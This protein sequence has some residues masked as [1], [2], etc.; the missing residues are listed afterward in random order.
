M[1]ELI[2]KSVLFFLSG[3]V[4]QCAVIAQPATYGV[5]PAPFSS[6]SYHELAPVFY[7]N[8]I[9]F[10]TNRD[11]GLSEYS[12]S[13]N[14]GFLKIFYT[15]TLSGVK[16]SDARLFS[17]N[18]KTKLN[19]GPVTFN[20][21]FDTIYFSRN[22]IVEGKLGNI[23]ASKNKLGLFFSVRSGKK[24]SAPRGLRLNN[25]YYNITTPCLSPDGK[26]MYF[27][28]DK[29]GGYGGS[30]L[31]YSLWRNDYWE[32][33]VNLG[34]AIN[35]EGNESYPFI[36]GDGELLF[37]SD[38][39]GGNGGKDI[40]YSRYS[41]TTW[42][43]P[44]ALD[45][46]VNSAAD[47][48]GIISDK[49]LGKGYF[50]SNRSGKTLD[51]YQF[52]TN[53][54]QIFYFENQRPDQYCFRFR[55][56]SSVVADPV[57]F[58]YEWDFGDGSVA[59]GA[60]TEHCFEGPGTYLINE[61][62]IER[63]TGRL[64]LNKLSYWLELKRVE[65]PFIHSDDAAIAGD[66]MTFD[67]TYSLFTDNDIIAHTWDFGDGTRESG[68]I[69]SH[70]YK[71]PGS[72]T[73]KLGLLLQGH[74]SMA[75]V[76]R[77]AVSKEVKI[78]DDQSQLEAF[79]KNVNSYKAEYHDL[80][81]TPNALTRKVY[82]VAEA[83]S[84]NALF[85]LEVERSS[86]RLGVSNPIFSQL[87]ARYFVR[88][89]FNIED[90]TYSYIIDEAAEPGALHQSFRDASSLGYRN[91]RIRTFIAVT[92]AEKELISFKMVYGS[93]ADIF[94]LRNEA[95]LSSTGYEYLDQMVSL[96]KKYPD[97]MLLFGN[98]LDN[99]M[100]PAV[101]AELSRLR[102]QSIVTYMTSRG[103]SGSRLISTGFGSSRPVTAG[104]TEADRKKNRRLEVLIL[105]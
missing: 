88:E 81:D 56:D 66:T 60:N 74:D 58:R 23:P 30:D 22:M 6:K 37:A 4:L 13:Q 20:A 9:V 69:I 11:D 83:L 55:D 103:I 18:L 14:L 42:L 76:S 61:N 44:V 34:P 25:E 1:S 19:D 31:Y 12:N 40:F 36:P 2:R 95:R 97:I 62:I 26:R 104:S 73:V 102:A 63:T 78:M 94:F 38:G 90:S 89:I 67:A 57:L 64:Y 29:P 10:C 46:P 70:V 15:D 77:Q 45:T 86:S 75:T 21:T 17:K 39:H 35:T 65:Q 8:G 3:V 82:S 87:P 68:N 7:L 92:P 28:S 51:I 27:A 48:F 5:S 99:S 72:Y 52:R 50:S 93:L 43:V 80:D 47:D 59:D 49:Y 84:G 98:H 101:T 24:W 41:D 33:P 91:S 54:Q 53:H 85:Q 16:W 79:R 71:N 105:N 32:S 96:M 100:P